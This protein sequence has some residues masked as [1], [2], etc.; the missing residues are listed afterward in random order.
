MTSPL[1]RHPLAGGADYV[2][3]YFDAD[4][5]IYTLEELIRIAIVVLGSLIDV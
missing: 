2:A 3:E 5:G 4:I 1:L